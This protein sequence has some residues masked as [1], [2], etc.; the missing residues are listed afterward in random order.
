MVSKSG[1][2]VT[3]ERLLKISSV[4]QGVRFPS[5]TIASL[6]R[7]VFRTLRDGKSKTKE[8]S[9]P[10]NKILRFKPNPWQTSFQFVEMMTA[11]AMLDGISLAEEIY[12]G[13]EL[14][15]L[16]PLDT[17]RLIAVEQRANGM[18][19]YLYRRQNGDRRTI[20][21]EEIF[22]L[23]G[24]GSGLMHDF[25]GISLTD[26]MR[27]TAGLEL[28]IET[29]GASFFANSAMPRV[30]LESPNEIRE[31]TRRRM[32]ADWNRSYGGIEQ[33]G[34]AL[35]EAGTKINVLSTKNDE[36][37]FIETKQALL[38]DFSR[39]T[40]VTPH[41]LHNLDKSSYNNV[42]EMSRETV[43]YTI[44][45]WVERWEQTCFRDLLSEED[46]EQDR[47]VEF[48]IDGLLR[49]DT[50]SRAEFYSKGINAGWLTRNEVRSFENLNPLEGLDDPLQPQNMMVVG[51]EPPPPPGPPTPD[52]AA[53]DRDDMPP[54]DS[55]AL[56]VARAA[57]QRV[58]R[59]ERQ[60]IARLA[61]RNGDRSESDW[62]DRVVGFY[63]DHA[64]FL[65]DATAMS[66]ERAMRWCSAQSNYVQSIGRE[67]VSA[68]EE[69]DWWYRNLGEAL[70][71][72]VLR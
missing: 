37:Q 25:L 20:L 28:A 56:A 57:V 3:K 24:F 61:E 45:P 35:L 46:R 32:K 12:E 1:V 27:D 60:G 7:F 50:K 38:G 16:V 53:D 40:D 54:Q 64:R 48:I 17:G 15:A 39:Y 49:G 31:E 18:L 8:T 43:V 63:R 5:Q 55:R 69:D 68:L 51:E 34:T 58:I 10:L 67:G 71:R 22:A 70:V 62:R 6:P 72:E 42:E 66:H 13:N 33:H 44:T 47:Y 41:R 65:A 2:R 14:Q 19:R 23:V 29:Y 11:R 59:K 21:Q 9:H 26:S 52:G 36:A 30:V 4:L